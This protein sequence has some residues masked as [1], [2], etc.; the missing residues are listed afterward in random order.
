MS[1][2][3]LFVSEILTKNLTLNRTKLD[4]QISFN[5]V[6]AHPARTPRFEILLVP[7]CSKLNTFSDL[8][9]KCAF[10]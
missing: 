1:Y 8:F 6:T 2:I 7:G 10:S 9:T 4:F 3:S 5:D